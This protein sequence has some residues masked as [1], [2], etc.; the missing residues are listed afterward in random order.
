MA[1]FGYLHDPD[2]WPANRRKEAE[3]G[4]RFFEK[5]RH[6]PQRIARERAARTIQAWYRKLRE[7]REQRKLKEEEEKRIRLKQALAK[8]WDKKAS[9][10]GTQTR[11][12]IENQSADAMLSLTAEDEQDSV[13]VRHVS[14]ACDTRDLSDV[15]AGGAAMS[16]S[17]QHSGTAAQG[18]D[19]SGTTGDGENWPV[20]GSSP[21][22]CTSH[23]LAPNGQSTVVASN[24]C[25]ADIDH[26]V[27]EANLTLEEREARQR[28]K[29]AEEARLKAQQEE[30][31][32]KAQQEEERQRQELARIERQKQIE[33]EQEAERKRLEL[34]RQ[35]AEAKAKAEAAEAERQ[36]QL[37]LP[38]QPSAQ[39][40]TFVHRDEGW[41]SE[42]R[43]SHSQDS[44][45]ASHR[46]YHF[47]D[48]TSVTFD[49]LFGN[50]N[51]MVGQD[52]KADPRYYA[53]GHRRLTYDGFIL[54]DVC[55]YIHLFESQNTSAEAK[56]RW[57]AVLKKLV[58]LRNPLAAT[59]K[60]AS[61][62]PSPLFRG[63]R[64]RSSSLPDISSSGKRSMN[65]SF[66]RKHSILQRRGQVLR[67][68]LAQHGGKVGA[69]DA[70]PSHGQQQYFGAYLDA[71]TPTQQQ[72]H[73]AFQ[74]IFTALRSSA[75]APML[76]SNMH[77]IEE[78]LASLE[79]YVQV[80]RNAMVLDRDLPSIPE[81]REAEEAS[82]WFDDSD[83]GIE[84]RERTMRRTR[85]HSLSSVFPP[86]HSKSSGPTKDVRFSLPDIRSPQPPPKHPQGR[87][88]KRS[89]SY[90]QLALKQR[91]QSA[92]SLPLSEKPPVHLP[93][94]ASSKHP[95]SG[96]SSTSSPRSTR[97]H[98]SLASGTSSPGLGKK[99]SS[100]R[101]GS[102]SYLKAFK[103]RLSLT[104]LKATNTTSTL[105]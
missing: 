66:A 86:M 94:L 39:Q 78:S 76:A 103:K 10:S 11:A 28:A 101:E 19:L 32:L 80:A 95:R 70:A 65:R 6:H 73:P 43:Q 14:I 30:A 52:G 82:L 8:K 26:E 75:P 17:A 85:S 74:S 33:A 79:H 100:G 88:L 93:P 72:I 34:A 59:Q 5:P 48:D 105:V 81:D 22:T 7:R 15:S 89:T 47:H 61:G 16:L 54:P 49:S 12:S 68:Q 35:Q 71:P 24:V 67:G 53:C 84:S 96:S 36:Q 69:F 90:Q 56:L 41:H 23:P 46:G 97:S 64:L 1:S 55:A 98:S 87:L 29:E 83:S 104:D 21:S 51:V 20:L 91:R 9:T 62:S 25:G 63:N 40:D 77:A 60:I 2:L 38:F 27:H 13:S 57:K 50:A 3:D 42:R 44:M 45:R 31:R 58:P 99:G 4:P 92:A 37:Q 18:S 102:T